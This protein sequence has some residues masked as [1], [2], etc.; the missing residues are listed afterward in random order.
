MYQ[1]QPIR[2]AIEL[3]LDG[4]FLGIV[5]LGEE[6]TRRSNRGIRIPAPHIKRTVGPKAKLL[7]DNAEYVLGLARADSDQDKVKERHELFIA[8]VNDCAMAT[9]NEQVRAVATFLAGPKLHASD[10]PAG[11]DPSVNLTFSFDGELPIDDWSVQRYWARVQGAEEPDDNEN[12]TETDAT[13]RMTCIVCGQVRPILR[14]HPIKIK[15]IPGGQ[16]GKDL[17]SAN[18]TAFESYGLANSEIAPTCQACAEAYGNALNALLSDPA[19]HLRLK[20]SV[21]A[22][23]WSDPDNAFDL[24]GLFN[25]P[26]A[27]AREVGELLTAAFEAKP[28]ALQLDPTKFHAMSLGPS[29]ARVVVRDWIDTTLAAAQFRLARYFAAQRLV[30][31]EGQPGPWLPIWRLANATVRDPKRDEPASA[32]PGQLLRFA[33]LG[34]PLPDELMFQVVRRIRADGQMRRDRVVL[35][36]MIL[37]QANPLEDTM[38]SLDVD[39]PEPAYHCGRLLYLL[40]RI[41]YAALGSV[42]ATVVDKYFAGASATPELIFGMLI[43]NA[44]NHLSK[45]RREGTRDL[46]KKKTY[47]ALKRRLTEMLDTIQDFPSS[48][49]AREQAIFTLGFYHQSAEDRRQTADRSG[50]SAEELAATGLVPEESVEDESDEA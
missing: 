24:T 6:Q 32:I 3:G 19:T 2:Y 5:P 27:R 8:L 11:F 14:R 49:P 31:Y 13:N 1:A 35:I 7:A 41:Q 44:Q 29:G 15:G 12:E 42:N 39:R 9:G 37:S 4:T 47:Y 23:W 21:Y 26:E 33:L 22:Y 30:D 48:L 20:N 50:K 25:E 43:R 38:S 34:T 10:F 16:I 28:E 46:R 45:L 17:I 36:K 40:D 18:N